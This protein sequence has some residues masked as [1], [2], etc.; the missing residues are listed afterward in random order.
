[1]AVAWASGPG[2]VLQTL[3]ARQADDTRERGVVLSECAVAAASI[4]RAG[5]RLVARAGQ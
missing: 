4:V 5:R 2:A 1:M 3:V